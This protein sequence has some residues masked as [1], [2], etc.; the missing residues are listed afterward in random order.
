MALRDLFTGTYPSIY[1]VRTQAP[2]PAGR[3][4]LTPELLA[5]APSGYLFG[6]TM[7]VGMGWNPDDVNRDAVMIV[8]TASIL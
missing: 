4:P 8:S 2:G 7:N 5:D 1:E 3:L 6:M